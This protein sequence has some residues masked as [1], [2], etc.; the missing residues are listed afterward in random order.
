MATVIRNELVDLQDAD[1]KLISGFPSVEFAN[2]TSP[3]SARTNVDEILSGTQ[4]PARRPRRR[5]TCDNN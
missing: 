4:R 2:V 1:I 3:L 5:R